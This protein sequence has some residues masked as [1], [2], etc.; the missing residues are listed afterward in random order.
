M[1][2]TK[3]LNITALSLVSLA[4][5][6][7][8]LLGQTPAVDLSSSY[9]DH[10]GGSSASELVGW[11]FTVN[12][13]ISVTD[14]GLYSGGLPFGGPAPDSG[15]VGLW[16][17]SGTLLASAN[18]QTSDALTLGFKYH[19]VPNT[20]LNV[21]QNY[22]IA[23]LLPVSGG[24]SRWFASGTV[25]AIFSPEISYVDR[26]F[27]IASDLSSPPTS[28][29]WPDGGAIGFFAA[30]FEYTTIPEPS[31]FTLLGLGAASLMVYR[32]R[33]C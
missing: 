5:A 2:I 4:F 32:R 1:K 27:I 15:T 28:D 31:T 7:M 20:L 24:G 11:E 13:P 30:S 17:S 12:S 23:A 10:V 3:S 14:L 18:V 19:E 8:P 33:Q 29:N 21:G 25:G 16:T 26:R 9:I 6:G 22:I